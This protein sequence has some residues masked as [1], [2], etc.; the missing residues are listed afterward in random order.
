MNDPYKV[1]NISATA[2][3]EEVKRAYR[4]LARKY[5]PDNYH[6]NPLAD[7][8]QE[9]MKEI[10]EAYEQ[11]Q[12]QRKGGGAAQGGYYGAQRSASYGANNYSANPTMQQIRAAINRGDITSAERLLNAVSTHDAEWYFL[13]GIVYARRGWFDDAKRYLETACSMDPGNVEYQ[14]ALARFKNQ[15]YRPSGFGTYTTADCG[16]DACT[17]WCMAMMCCNLLGG[18]FYCVPCIC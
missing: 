7:L 3:D 18:G 4:E 5:H 1:L 2:S 16:N 17:Q 9:K 12:K 13:S 10:N 8:A 11:I 14:N 15:G 6:D